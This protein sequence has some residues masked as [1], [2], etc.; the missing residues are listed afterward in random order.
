[1]LTYHAADGHPH[2]W[3][4]W[5]AAGPRSMTLPELPDD[6]VASPVVA[7]DCAV[8]GLV[9]TDA[10]E[11][12]NAIRAVVDAQND[13]AISGFRAGVTRLSIAQQ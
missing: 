11:S 9:Q 8:V 3:T 1:V 10:F 5:Q 4:L 13:D 6:L 7:L 12:W 2:A